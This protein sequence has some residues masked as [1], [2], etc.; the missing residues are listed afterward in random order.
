MVIGRGR[1]REHPNQHCLLL[2]RVLHN[3]RLRIHTPKGTPKGSS[4]FRSLPV[5]M[6]LLLRK[7]TG[8]K[9]GHAQNLLP[10]RATSGHGLFQSRNWRHFR[11]KGSTRADMAQ[12]P[13][14]H[15]QNILPDRV[16][17]GHVTSAN[18]ALSVP[19]YY[20][21]HM[22]VFH[23]E[24]TGFDHHWTRILSMYSAFIDTAHIVIGWVEF[25]SKSRT[26][27]CINIYNLT[28]VESNSD[29]SKFRLSRIK[30]LV[31]R[32]R[33]PYYLHSLSQIYLSK[34]V[35]YLGIKIG[36]QVKHPVIDFD[37]FT[38]CYFT[39]LF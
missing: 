19:I 30:V 29:E 12:H 20:F 14:A 6:L 33:K 37:I 9:A 38:L 25:L 36:S 11:S 35:Y 27:L 34:H 4:D 28:P 39:C 16:T 23:Q 2:L 26:S 8:G 5:A 22:S 18:V 31:P 13:V 3:F 21:P 10:V 32:C 17:S 1:R 15:A 24:R 7:K